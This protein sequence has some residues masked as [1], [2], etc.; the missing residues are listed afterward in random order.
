MPGQAVAVFLNDAT[1]VGCFSGDLGPG[2]CQVG[3]LSGS[4]RDYTHPELGVEFG[5]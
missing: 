1:T 3:P 2:G 4:Y 5:L